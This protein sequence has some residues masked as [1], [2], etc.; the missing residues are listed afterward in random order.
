MAITLGGKTDKDLG[1][2]VL[3][4]TNEPVL[5][6][7][8][9]NSVVISGRMGAFDFGGELDTR[10]FSLPCAIIQDNYYDLQKIVRGLA[11]HLLDS[12][13]KPRILDLIFDEEPDKVYKVRYSGS[14]DLKKVA[15]LGQFTL[16]L[17]CYDVAARSVYNT[18]DEITGNIG[19][20]GDSTLSPSDK[21]S[22]DVTGKT[23]VQVNNF[24]TLVTAPIT[25][26]TGTFTTLSLTLNGKTFHYNE[27]LTA[28]TLVIDHEKYTAANGTY[29][30]LNQTSGDFVE[31]LAGY[32]DITIDGSN[33]N[34]TIKFKFNPKF[35]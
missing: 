18:G 6:S 34:C 16:P 13:G 8:R 15:S 10:E 1:I 17:K 23:T 22:F 27:A 33:L 35:I 3:M 31:L 26:I 7:T 14:L 25:E 12:Y 28:G 9:D 24:G 29:N 32:N 21:F 19:V 20:L 2:V 30:K 11:V 4:D 5:P